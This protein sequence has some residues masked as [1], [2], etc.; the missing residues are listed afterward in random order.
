M[1][2][3]GGLHGNEPAGA[4]AAERVLAALNRT[5]PEMNGRLLALRGNRSALAREQRYLV[6]DLNRRW[7]PD[8]VRELLAADPAFDEP[9]DSEQRDL[10]QIMQEEAERSGQPLVTLDLHTTSGECPPFACMSD[11]LRNRDI[12]FALGIPV[13]LG[14]E[15]VTDGTMLGYLADLGHVGV[16]VEAGQHEAP[17][18]EELHVAAIA[19]AMVA[20]G[21]LTAAQV[22]DYTEHVR[23]LRKAARGYPRVVE[24]VYRHGI[25]PEDQFRM[26]P[27][28]SSFQRLEAGQTLAEDRDGKV[29]A[30]FPGRML[31][32][33]YQGLGE[34]GFFIGRDVGPVRLGLSH[35]LR[36]ARLDDA[37][38]LLPGVRRADPDDHNHL[39]V[40]RGADRGWLRDALFL[41]GFRH[42][43][44]AGDRIVYSRRRPDADGLAGSIASPGPSR[45]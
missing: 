32:P 30:R 29:R 24:I 8:R 4:R 14:L 37:L 13:I 23:R 16:A 18:T 44:P 3:I 7:T 31:L 33:L 27:G 2:V 9:E 42:A 39:L 43:R 25:E 20:S 36:R 15:E 38:A 11:A 41:C 28:F 34:D 40:A 35:V 1:I 21:L 26:E 22:P 5:S 10:V 17:A 45:R 12:A 6:R 19:V